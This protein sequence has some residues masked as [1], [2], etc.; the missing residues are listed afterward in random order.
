MFSK[1]DIEPILRNYIIFYDMVL[2][3]LAGTQSEVS[4]SIF[5]YL[6]FVCVIIRI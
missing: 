4:L 1:Y 3:K 2:N 5:I 6:W